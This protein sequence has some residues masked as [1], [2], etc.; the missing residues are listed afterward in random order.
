MTVTPFILSSI[1][2]LMKGTILFFAIF[3]FFIFGKD[4][5]TPNFAMNLVWS[6]GIGGPLFLSSGIF[7]ENFYLI[8]GGIFL[9][10]MLGLI[11]FH[12]VITKYFDNKELVEEET[13]TKK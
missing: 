13:K 8:K 3:I 6:F 1:I 10:M 7:L 5:K 11:L 2:L 4:G 9:I 12:Q